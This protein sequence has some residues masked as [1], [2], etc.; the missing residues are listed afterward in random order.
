M[1]NLN[2]PAVYDKLTLSPKLLE[3]IGLGNDEALAGVARTQLAVVMEHMALRCLD[4]S[5]APSAVASILEV[6]RKLSLGTKP[7][8]SAQSA[9]QVVIN[10]T[11]TKDSDEKLVIDGSAETL[12]EKS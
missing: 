7:D 9:P 10:I 2:N 6:L 8:P 1:A 5:T 4:P 12:P 3:E 11:R